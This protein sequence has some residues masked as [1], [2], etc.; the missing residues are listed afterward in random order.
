MTTPPLGAESV[1]ACGSACRCRRSGAI[2]LRPLLFF[3][4]RS[5]L[6]EVIATQKIL[7][8]MFGEHLC[9]ARVCNYF[10]IILIPARLE[11]GVHGILIS[12]A[13]SDVVVYNS[14]LPEKMQCE[15]IWHE[16]YHYVKGRE[17]EPNVP[18]GQDDIKARAF[19]LLML[20]DQIY[21]ECCL[22]NKCVF[23]NVALKRNWISMLRESRRN[24]GNY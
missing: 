20:H 4:N 2:G 16:I 1:V 3:F 21:S 8:A 10:G 17:I 18:Y 19:A 22:R 11:D 15:A 13:D 9:A 12:R 7:F 23:E 5:F 14:L 24:A 6:E